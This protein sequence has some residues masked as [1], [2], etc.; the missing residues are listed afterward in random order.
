MMHGQKTTKEVILFKKMKYF[1]Y[2]KALSEILAPNLVPK[3][4]N[5]GLSY[6]FRM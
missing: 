3:G 5:K 1:C 4:K 2:S 6:S